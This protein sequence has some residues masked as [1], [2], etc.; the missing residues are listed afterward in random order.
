MKVRG[1]ISLGIAAFAAVVSMCALL[2]CA[3]DLQSGAYLCEPDEP[4][5]CPSDWLCQCRGAGCQW[6]C[7]ASSGSYCGDGQLAP[8][9]ECDG[10]QFTDGACNEGGYPFCRTDCTQACTECGNGVLEATPSGDREECDD[11]NQVM[12]DGCSPSC[13]LARCG[14]GFVDASLQEGCDDGDMNSN[15]PGARCRINCQEQRCGDGIVDLATTDGRPAEICDDGNLDPTDGCTPDCQSE[16]KC[17]NGYIDFA[18]GEQCDDGNG[19]SHD[20]CSS[21]CFKETLLTTADPMASGYPAPDTGRGSRFWH[22]TAYDAARGRLVLFG[23]RVDRSDVDTVDV[24]DTWEWDGV[25]WYRMAGGGPGAISGHDMTYHAGRKRVVLLGNGFWE[26]NGARWSRLP[27][28]ANSPSPSHGGPIAYD[29]R[30]DR[31]VMVTATTTWE[32]ESSTHRWHNVTPASGPS[33]GGGQTVYDPSVDRTVLVGNG[34]WEWNG[35]NRTWTQ[36]SIEQFPFSMG[37]SIVYDTGRRQI[38]WVLDGQEAFLWNSRTR[39]LTPGPPLYTPDLPSDQNGAALA[40]HGATGMTVLIAGRYSSSIRELR[41]NSWR[42]TNSLPTSIFG[43]PFLKVFDERRGQTWML[44]LGAET[45]NWLSHGGGWIQQPSSPTRPASGYLASYDGR[46][47]RVI[48]LETSPEQRRTW[49]W[50]GAS[51]ALRPSGD[52]P[53]LNYD[54]AMV[55]DHAN[56]YALYVGG[57][58]GDSYGWNGTTWQGVGLARDFSRLGAGMAFDRVRGRAVR[59]GGHRD[60]RATS[61][62]LELLPDSLWTLITNSGPPPAELI[63]IWFD[64]DRKRT[65]FAEDGHWEWDGASWTDVTQGA[66]SGPRTSLSA[67]A[68]SSALKRPVVGYGPELTA[69]PA[70]SLRYDNVAARE[71]T[72]RFG[73]DTDADGLM[74]CADPDCWRSCTPLCSPGQSCPA[75]APRCGDGVCNTD[76]EDCR[77]CPSDCGACPLVCGDF[78]CDSGET[79]TSCPGDCR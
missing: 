78:L 15:E 35:H 22:A 54:G 62:L 27:V 31:L 66:S 46:R 73:F 11:G 48:V 65:I 5:G 50:N 58:Y 33:P 24:G 45:T 4:G 38:V 41:S 47:D 18:V 64:P 74:A 19:K 63:D 44:G 39:T 26:W 49:E 6:R 34:I 13:L 23:G 53:Y 7:Y 57:L 76:L 10:V 30:R 71:E 9:E 51:W 8:G 1:F 55:Y 59:Y 25:V 52:L 17:G 61:A 60:G 68:K 32:W 16:V 75:N 37:K 72:C 70:V 12:G 29:S 77:L 42:Y 2:S 40:H 21:D 56:G 28:A 69:G 67:T 36:V 79:A 43:G 3:S 20:G 14:D